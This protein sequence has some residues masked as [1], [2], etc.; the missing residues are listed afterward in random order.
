MNMAWTYSELC[1]PYS[2]LLLYMPLYVVLVPPSQVEIS[3]DKLARLV[4]VGV[5][6]HRDSVCFF[7]LSDT[8][9]VIIRTGFWDIRLAMKVSAIFL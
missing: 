6:E 3:R 5:Y 2:W 1:H 7:L 4:G 9:L 8:T